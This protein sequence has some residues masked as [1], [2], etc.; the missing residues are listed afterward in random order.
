MDVVDVVIIGSGASGSLLAAKLSQAGKKVVVLETGPERRTQDLYSS[1]LWAR[2]LKW[3]GPPTET[4]GTDPISVNFG[5]GWGAGGAALHH[6]A[7][8]LRRHSDDFDMFSRFG[9]SLDW[10][11]SYDEL[12]PYYDQ[13]QREVGISG[14]AEAEV[15]RPAGDP[16]PMPPLKPFGQALLVA[17]GFTKLG[18][19]TS[20][21]PMG[22]NS[23]P[24]N[25]RPACVYDGWC[26]AGCPIL[27]LANPLALYLPQAQRA[28]A[29]ILYNSYA[30]RV[31]TDEAGRRA[32]GVEYFDA[33]GRKRV[34]EGRV[35][36]IAAY[37]VQTPR[38]L[39]NSA[40]P[41][42]P[43]GLANSS[44]LVGKY[45]MTH[46][47]ANVYGLF[48]E[49]TENY[50]G[51]TGGQL[52]CQEDYVK[53]SRRGYVN[54]ATWLIANALKPNDLLGLVNARP[55]LFGDDLHSFM[56]TT[57]RHLATMTYVGEEL[58]KPENQLILSTQKDRFGVPIAR[59]TH[60]F[61][62]D[63]IK[64]YD[65]GMKQGEAV[66]KAAGA[67]DVWVG[68][69]VRMHALGGAIMGSQPRNSV[70]NSYGQTHD[71]VNLF[72]AGN[73]VCPTSAA[74]NPIFTIHAMTLRT[75]RYMLD[76]WSS[77]A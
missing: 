16:Y 27:A 23:V 17:K 39:L 30:V 33:D 48:H 40:T 34:Q 8:W 64:C 28:G 12:R 67:Y 73:S 5:S 43:A 42:H 69:R 37:A 22:I 58:P 36:V 14:D 68:E 75:S 51:T 21:L 41:K 4:L 66:F 7:V 57:A 2:R 31:L 76:N 1:Q 62:S 6:Y 50:R 52:L 9:V 38:I 49:E 15:W 70:T 65:E 61:G 20:P 26:D 54:S 45:M 55:Q 13:L 72:V 71:M 44:G 47:S 77:L 24:Y 29:A 60:A 35:I 18:L 32:T 63:D 46:T 11:I 10:P 3:S 19:R 25:G 53:D 56:K 74:V 59:I